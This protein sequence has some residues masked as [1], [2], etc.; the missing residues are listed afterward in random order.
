MR[1]TKVVTWLHVL[2]YCNYKNEC[3]T[4][5]ILLTLMLSAS[6]MP[7]WHGLPAILPLHFAATHLAASSPT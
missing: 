7:P 6:L 4:F 1:V 3:H 2:Y 5:A